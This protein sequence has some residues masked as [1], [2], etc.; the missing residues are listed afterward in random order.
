MALDIENLLE[1]TWT[2]LATNV[3]SGFII[4]PLKS[5]AYK[6]FRATR[7]TG[8]AGPAAEAADVK[9]EGLD[10]GKALPLF[11][12][13]RYDEISNSSGIDVYGYFYDSD[14]TNTDNAD[15]LTDL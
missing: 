13:S 9:D 15:L 11:E 10:G 14:D 8:D 2:I 4:L 5:G 3:T 7:P 12:E 1:R 6:F